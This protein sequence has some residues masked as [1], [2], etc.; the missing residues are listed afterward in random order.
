MALKLDMYGFIVLA[1]NTKS[2]GY[3]VGVKTSAA[4]IRST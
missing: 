2:T 4:I 3:T 1:L